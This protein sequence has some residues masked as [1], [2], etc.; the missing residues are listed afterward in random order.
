MVEN[1]VGIRNF[2]HLEKKGVLPVA[3]VTRKIS[4]W[5]GVNHNRWNDMQKST[6]IPCMIPK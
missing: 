4:L 1:V 6:T 3:V 5:H 2:N